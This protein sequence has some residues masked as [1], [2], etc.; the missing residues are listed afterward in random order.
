MPG[1]G[2]GNKYSWNEPPTYTK[3]VGEYDYMVGAKDY[4]PVELKDIESKMNN[5]LDA[6]TN[7]VNNCNICVYG[8]TDLSNLS[9][10]WN[11]IFMIEEEPQVILDQNQILG[12][13]NDIQSSLIE[14]QNTVETYFDDANI[15][16]GKINDALEKLQSNANKKA[17]AERDANSEDLET[18]L[19]AESIL[20]SFKAYGREYTKSDLSSIGKWVY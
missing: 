4:K 8:S 15:M 18:K 20:R 9:A 14:L 17:V 16:I 7:V 6:I 5:M 1:I 3:G 19:C 12:I 10:L 2:M 11:T 13:G